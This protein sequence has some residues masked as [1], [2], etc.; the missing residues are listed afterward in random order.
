LALIQKNSIKGEENMDLGFKGKVAFVTGCGSPI[1]FGR[2]IC[3]VLAEEG[4]KIIGCDLNL[5]G[6]KETIKLV[7]EAGSEGIAIKMDVTKKDEVE[8][9]VKE[10][11]AR[12]GQI[13]VLIN[14][15][16]A[17]S[18]QHTKFVDMTD[19]QIDFDVNVNLYGQMNV[20]KA[21]L[22]HMIERRTGRIVNFT[23]GRGIPGLSIYG[24]AKAGIIEWTKALAAEVAP[25]N[26]Y[27]NVF[28]PGLSKTGLIK[29]QSPEFI[30]M[31]TRSTKQKRLCTPDDVAP[32]VVFLASDKNSYMTGELVHI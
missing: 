30:E 7:E 1:G 12:F 28:G 3:Q 16:G 27:V 6:A 29:G 5:E 26:I 10:G 13:D 15:A 19:E 8:A 22:P 25:Y 21:I 31:V 24:A 4:C 23:G 20:A 2:K 17:S 11:L 14:C 18:T 32:F 9:A